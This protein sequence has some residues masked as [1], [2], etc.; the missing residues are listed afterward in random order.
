[1][2]NSGDTL[3]QF[4]GTGA[5]SW[6]RFDN[7][8]GVTGGIGIFAVDPNDPNRLY[9]S[10]MRSPANGGP[11]MIFSS[12]GGQ[13]WDNDPEL[14]DLMTGS[15]VFKYRTERGPSNFT[16]FVGYPQPTLVAF[17]PEDPDI[18]VAGGRDSGVFLSTNGGQNWGLLTDPFDSGNSG[19]P[20]LPRPWFAYFDHEP[21]GEI[22]LYIGTQGRGV[23]RFEITV[24][25][26]DCNGPY[27]TDEGVDVALDGTR[28]TGDPPLDYA[29][30]FY[31]DDDF[32]NA[33]GPTP[34]FDRVGQDGVYPIAL[35]VTDPDGAFDIAECTVTV[36]NV[37]PGLVVNSDLP[38]DEGSLVIVTGVA[39]DPG[40][41]EELTA[42]IDWDDG[43]V[44]PISGVLENVRP[45][46]TLTFEVS[47][48]YGDNGLYNVEVCAFDDDTS[49]CQTLAV[50]IVNVSP[51][52][53]IDPGQVTVI[54]EGDSVDVLA[55][56]SDPGWLDTYTSLIDWGTPAGD[57]DVGNLVV[58]VEGPPLDQG[59]VTGSHRYGDNG[60]FPVTVTVTDDNGGS[61][62]DSFDL[63]VNNIDPTAE[64]D[65]SGTILINGI[66]TFLASVGEPLD[67]TGRATDP[68]SDDLFLGWAWDDGSPVVTVEDLVNPPNPDPFPSPDVEP[69]DVTDV[70]THTF[71]S[72]CLY[73][74][75]F[76]VNDDD[77]GHS[78]DH[79]MVL[80]SGDAHRARL[81]GYWQHQYSGKG[82]I[83]FDRATLECYLAMVSYGSTVFNEVR[84]ASTIEQA[85]D[86]LF[87]K[88]N[89][90]S[91]REQ[92]DR[93]LLTVWLN[94]ANGAIEFTDVRD[95]VATAES[96]RLDPNAT[97]KEIREQT[98]ILH[99]INN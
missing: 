30:D 25:V 92:L 34:S 84:D 18:L 67:F 10:N 12:D 52:V 9:A 98:R 40:W 79:A 73:E 90:G 22:N 29:W 87:L 85:Y 15:G 6:T 74:I 47:H 21:A 19:I 3:W 24:P 41:L 7:N 32:G 94:I 17:D 11:Q 16:E 75:G 1:M 46:A 37:P 82:N 61:G 36:D 42:T 27:T 56:F 81:E 33:T 39:T 26:A 57:T 55:H 23:W 58:T 51:M 68:G 20:H 93:E 63:T 89:Q 86:V 50:E 28:S 99:Q 13:T 5:G 77:S 2:G 14:D 69:R 65:E 80:I 66:P 31:D 97:D 44:E 45:D 91:E 8:D 4:T 53:S 96:V 59:Q 38:Q 95:G 83:D 78:E 60:L 70:R 54:N 72:A 71:G 35:K 88:Q 64:I 62:S 48:T 49:T 43:T 76:L